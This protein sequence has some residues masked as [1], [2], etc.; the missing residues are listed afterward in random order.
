MVRLS[1]SGPRIAMLMLNSPNIPGYGHKA[2]ISNYMYCAQHGYAFIVER[3]PRK[4]DMDKTWMWDGKNE[5]L[6]V[7]SKPTLVARYLKSYDYLLFIDSDAVVVDPTRRIEDFMA[8]HMTDPGTCIV[9]AEDCRDKSFCWT[10]GM[11][12]TGAML[13]RNSAKTYE[14]LDRWF[15]APLTSDCAEW[16]EKHTREQQCLNILRD[17][18]YTGSNV[19]KIVPS[20]E[21]GGHD[22]RWLMHLMAMD[23]ADRDRII[24]E[25]MRARLREYFDGGGPPSPFESPMLGTAAIAIV[26]CVVVGLVIIA[27]AGS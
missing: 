23:V 27:I 19:I 11:L 17:K 4:E 18:Y 20:R 5:Y 21:L 2:A 6:F 7:W 15:A 22:G 12:N 25:H 10:P 26:V 3:C 1:C 16:R 9:A 14:I 8:Q 13:F 24:D